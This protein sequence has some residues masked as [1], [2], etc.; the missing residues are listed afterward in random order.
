MNIVDLIEGA[1]RAGVY[2]SLTDAG[3]VKVSGNEDAVVAII[4]RIREHKPEIVAM[5]RG[6]Q[7]HAIYLAR[8]VIARAALTDEQKALRLA[9][10]KR[11]PSIAPFW[12][13]MYQGRMEAGRP[14]INWL[15]DSQLTTGELAKK[16]GN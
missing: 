1:N 9:D 16:G 10:L 3:T 15:P 8:L 2:L 7:E 14:E 11:E 4:P 6:R 13:Q 12:V 5:L